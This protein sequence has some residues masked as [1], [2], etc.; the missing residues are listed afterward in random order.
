MM[1]QENIFL[2]WKV[3]K[4]PDSFIALCFLITKWFYC[5]YTCWEYLTNPLI[6]TALWYK[7]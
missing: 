4:E 3:V 7:S 1:K 5:I 6:P 2:C